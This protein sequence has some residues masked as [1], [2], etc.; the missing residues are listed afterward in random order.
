[1]ALF[2]EAPGADEERFDHSL[3]SGASVGKPLVGVSGK[4]MDQLLQL[5]GMSRQDVLVLN[6][7]RC[8][9]PRNQIKDYPDAITQC[10]SWVKKELDAYQP[11]VVVLAGNTSLK[12]VYGATASITGTHGVV[13]STSTQHPYGSR[14]WVPTFHPAYAARN[15]GAGSQIAL[16]IINDLRLAKSLL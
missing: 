7:I 16:D 8:R 10:D 6:R 14:I 2:L 4:L 3:P 9:P 5:A 15:G 1:M 12:A 11:A 13:R